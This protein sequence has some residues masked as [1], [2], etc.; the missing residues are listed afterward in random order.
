[1]DFVIETDRLVGG[2]GKSMVLREVSLR[3]P[4]ASIYGFLGPNGAG[5]TTALRMLLGLLRPFSGEI[6]LFAEPLNGALPG[7]L[8]R[9]GSLIEQ[10]SLYDHLTGEENLEIVRRLKFLKRADAGRAIEATG[11]GEYIQRPAGEYSR[12][13]RQRLGVAMAILG[14]PELLLLDEPMN[15]LDA[16]GLRSFRSVLKNLHQ[17]YGTTIVISSHQFEEVEQVATHIGI[18][19]SVGDLLFQGPR[20]QLSARVPQELVIKVDRWEDAVKILTAG[21]FKVDLQREHIVIQGATTEMA[22]EVNRLLVTNGIDIHHLAMDSATL[23]ALFVKV[24]T[25]VKAWDA[26]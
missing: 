11:V 21:N 2:Y 4:R 14:N 7:I 15:G 13:M 25:T 22:R 19:S 10:P 20:E 12:G 17:E 16:G 8:R 5:K 26:R 3:V 9:V 1:M 24:T 23:E 18:M 6:R